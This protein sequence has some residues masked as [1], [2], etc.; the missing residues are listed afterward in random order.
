MTHIVMNATVCE[1]WSSESLIFIILE[2]LI[3]IRVLLWQTFF[4]CVKV[5]NRLKIIFLILI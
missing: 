2:L 4:L 5:W 3:Q 1:V